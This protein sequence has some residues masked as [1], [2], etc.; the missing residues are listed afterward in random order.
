[1]GKV[2]ASPLALL[3]DNIG[4]ARAKKKEAE[5]LDEK[6][7]PILDKYALDKGTYSG[8]EYSLTVGERIESNYSV[9]KVYK[10]L[11]IKGLLKVVKVVVKTLKEKVTLADLDN[12]IEGEPKPHKT[13]SF[14]RLGK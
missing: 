3:I 11:G 8:M 14:S 6:L 5:E 4:A 1:M 13:Y 2:E 12:L 7:K 9:E 10:H